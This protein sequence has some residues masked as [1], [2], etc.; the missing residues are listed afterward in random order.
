MSCILRTVVNTAEKSKMLFTDKLLLQYDD[1]TSEM[2]EELAKS[3]ATK[4]NKS[5]A[6]RKAIRAAY[7]A[8]KAQTAQ[9]VSRK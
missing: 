4:P 8:Q 2:L 5:E 9:K 3:A 1:E 7:A 6:I